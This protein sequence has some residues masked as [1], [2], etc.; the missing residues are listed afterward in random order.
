MGAAK[1][2]EAAQTGKARKRRRRCE[3]LGAPDPAP[4]R[5]VRDQRERQDE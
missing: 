3:R 1:L 2:E 5:S 4:S